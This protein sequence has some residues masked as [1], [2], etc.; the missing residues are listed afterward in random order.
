MRH[1]H[2]KT[3]FY[4]IIIIGLLFSAPNL[5]AKLMLSHKI[6]IPKCK[7][8]FSC[9]KKHSLYASLILCLLKHFVIKTITVFL[10][11]FFFKTS[12]T[13]ERRGFFPRLPTVASYLYCATYTE[14]FFLI[15]SLKKTLCSQIRAFWS[16]PICVLKITPTIY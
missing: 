8:T 12:K 3:N 13:H 9:Q 5:G 4:I 11:Y 16:H 6:F 2:I 7:T 10:T 15:Q 1:H 14:I